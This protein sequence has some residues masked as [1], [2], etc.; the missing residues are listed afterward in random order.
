MSDLKAKG[1]TTVSRE[2][3]F[4]QVWEEP[5]SQAALKY[6]ISGRGLAKVCDRLK[7]PYPSRGWWARKVAGQKVVYYQLPE[8]D[9]GTPRTTRITPF[10]PPPAIPTEVQEQ[11]AAAAVKAGDVVVSKVLRCPHPMIAEWVAEHERRLQAARRDPNP[12]VRESVGA[13]TPLDHRRHRILDALFKAAER[14][15]AM[16]REDTRGPYLEVAGERIDFTLCEK[17]LQHRRP[18]TEDEKRRSGPNSRD[19]TFERMPSGR[20]SF[21]LETALTTLPQRVWV[22]TA[23]QPLEDSVSKILGSRNSYPVPHA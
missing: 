6:G 8:P 3:L 20:L 1:P 15:A 18:K 22:E 4:R 19:W 7:V 11:A 2:N 23:E 17:Q 21:T 9:A 16:V 5:M 13:L 14:Q 12:W 10:E